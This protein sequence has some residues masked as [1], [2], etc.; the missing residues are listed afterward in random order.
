MDP[1][2][3]ILC[4][5]NQK[6]KDKYQMTSLICGIQ[7]TTQMNL[8]TKQKHPHRHRRETYQSRLFILYT[9]CISRSQAQWLSL[10]FP[11]PCL[12]LPHPSA[13]FLTCF[14]LTGNLQDIQASPERVKYGV[15]GVNASSCHHEKRTM[16]RWSYRWVLQIL[17][18]RSFLYCIS[19]S[20]KKERKR[21]ATQLTFW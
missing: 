2:T 16:P 17:R 21:K 1:E 9:D 14:Y 11:F 4:E 3:I 5:A 6:E 19:C 18:S 13:T 7:N 15:K 20:R 10:I 8:F 12:F